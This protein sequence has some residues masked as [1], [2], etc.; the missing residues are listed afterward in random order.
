MKISMNTINQ[1][2]TAFLFIFVLAG[3]PID[4]QATASDLLTAISAKSLP[5][6]IV[7]G[8]NVATAVY[9][10]VT[11]WKNNR[12]NFAA[13]LHSTAWWQ[14]FA[15]IVISLFLLY[16]FQ[17]PDGTGDAIIQAVV[18]QDWWG[19]AVLILTNIARPIINKYFPKANTI[20]MVQ[21]SKGT[22]Q[23]KG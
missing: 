17:I 22:F 5:L 12:P 8:F 23:A 9:H 19:L 16:G 11:T 1:I 20:E 4:A 21:N 14:T 6:F 10:W 15:N 7:L 13:F 18:S 2:V 3:L